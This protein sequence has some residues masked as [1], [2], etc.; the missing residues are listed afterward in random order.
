MKKKTFFMTMLAVA[1]LAVA[2]CN[3]DDEK[4]LGNGGEAKVIIVAKRTLKVTED[5]TITPHQVLAMAEEEFQNEIA[6]HGWKYVDGHI[7]EQEGV[8][9]PTRFQ[10][11]GISVPDYFFSKGIVNEYTSAIPADAGPTIY[12]T[13]QFPYSYS[14]DTGI[15]TFQ[16]SELEGEYP[17]RREEGM[18]LLDYNKEKQELTVLYHLI[19]EHYNKHNYILMTYRRMTEEE[20]AVTQRTHSDKQN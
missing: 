9:D 8:V 3:N 18:T 20:L 14:S 2:S 1:G 16:S 19:L 4:E 11:V 17:A 10:M 7:V 6:E 12:T 13:T 15:I 5:G